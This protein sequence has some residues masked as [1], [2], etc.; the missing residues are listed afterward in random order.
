MNRKIIHFHEVCGAPLP[1]RPFLIQLL[2][3][4]EGQDSEPDP[5]RTS[6][7]LGEETLGNVSLHFE[8]F[9]SVHSFLCL[10]HLL[11][12]KITEQV[13]ELYILR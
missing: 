10:R 9:R 11:F 2:H 7:V 4:V 13:L 3:T 1:L 8:T 12:V 5:H 6:S